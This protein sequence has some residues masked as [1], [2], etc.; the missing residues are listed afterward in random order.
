MLGDAYRRDLAALACSDTLEV[1]RRS[2]VM[3]GVM[4]AIVEQV[5]Q[6]HTAAIDCLDARTLDGAQGAQL[7]VLGRIVGLWPRP[8][9]D[10]GDVA[11]FRPDSAP[12][13]P[14]RARVWIDGAPTSGTAPAG[15]V[16][17]RAAL[18]AKIRKN[19]TRHGSAPEL[20]AYGRQA[21]GVPITVRSVG[22]SDV[23]VIMATGAPASLVRAVTQELTTEEA[24]K[25]YQLPIPS[26]ARV[27]AV[28]FKRPAG[29]APDRATGRPDSSYL[30]VS[31]VVNS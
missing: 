4:S 23:E 15:D 6:L 17:Y 7:D 20:M 24:D 26:T 29:F 21:F 3:M 9:Q 10:A 13:A 1:F 5:Q 28:S 22:L 14:D 30:S 27:V 31:Y 2:P 18:R 25:T 16:L 8:A 12:R 11:Y 19:H